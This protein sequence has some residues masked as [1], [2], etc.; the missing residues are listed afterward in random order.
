MSLFLKGQRECGILN[1]KCITL[2]CKFFQKSSS[3]SKVHCTS[4]L[5][6]NNSIVI[7]DLW[8]P[9][10]CFSQ[11]HRDLDYYCKLMWERNIYIIYIKVLLLFFSVY[12]HVLTMVCLFSVF[13]REHFQNKLLPT[14]IQHIH[15]FPFLQFTLI[16]LF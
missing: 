5:Q 14:T 13:K 6:P 1:I 10:I 8:K 2:K 12:F 7:I 4:Q 9:W 11:E 3:P 16:D 15:M